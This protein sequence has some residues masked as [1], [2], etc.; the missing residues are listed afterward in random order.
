[1]RKFKF[2]RLALLIVSF[3]VGMMGMC[4]LGYHLNSTTG[5]PFLFGTY[6]ATLVVLPV[7]FVVLVAWVLDE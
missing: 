2:W 3:Y 4:W 6:L 1:M 5:N 7:S